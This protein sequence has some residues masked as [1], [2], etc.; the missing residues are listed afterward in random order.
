MQINLLNRGVLWNLMRVTVL[1]IVFA[2]LGMAMANASDVYSQQLLNRKVTVHAN[3]KQIAE[4]LET[5]QK[6]ANVKFIYSY[7]IIDA[8]RIVDVDAKEKKLKDVLDA[9]LLPNGVTYKVSNDKLIILLKDNDEYQEQRPLDIT[10]QNVTGKVLDEDNQPIPGVYIIEKGTSN[11]T[12]SGS[13]GG[14]SIGVENENAILVFS[15][16]GYTKQEVTVGLQENITLVLL[17]DITALEEIVVIGYGTVEKRDVTGAIGSVNA[18][19]FKEQPVLR[20][21]QILQGRTAGVNVT[22][23]SGAPGGNVTIRIRGANSITGNNDPLYV[24]DGFVGGDFNDVN[25]SDIENIQV[26]KDASATAIYGSRGA[27]GVVLITTKTGQAGAPKF[28]FTTRYSSSKVLNTWDLMDASTFANVVNQRASDLGLAPRFTDQ[29]VADFKTNGGTDWQNEIFR[30]G[31]G[32][33]YQL[34]YSGGNEAVKYFISGNLLDQDG[35]VINSYFKRYSVRT[36]IDAQLSKKFRARIKMNYIRRETNNVQGNGNIGSSIGGVTGWAPT[37]PAYD[38]NGFLTV[39]DPISSIKANPIELAQNDNIYQSNNLTTNGGFEYQILPG[40]SFD[41]GLGMSYIN[42]QDKNFSKGSIDKNASSGRQSTEYLFLQNTNNLTYHKIYKGVHD[43]SVTGALEHQLRKQ[44]QFGASANKLQFPDLGYNNITLAGGISTNAYY[45]KQTIQ[46]YIG[47]VSYQFKHRYLITA[48]A[49][50]DGSSK[51]RGSNRYSTFPSVALGWRL[52]E[53]AFM[54]GGFFDDL[55]LRASWGKTGSQAIPVYG[56]ITSFSSDNNAAGVGFTN[57]TLTP[58]II[59]GNPGNPNLKWETTAQLNFGVDMQILTG[60]LGLTVDYFDKETSDLLL[61]FPLPSYAGGG[62]ILRNVGSTKNSGFEFSLNGTIINTDQLSW[63]SSLNMTFLKNEVVSL[64]SN[65]RI[66]VDGNAGAGITNLPEGVLKPGE[67]LSAFWGLKYLG[68]WK[69]GEETEAAIYKNVPG[70]SH[71]EDINKDGVIG[72]DDYQIIGTG[73]PQTLW[74][75]NNTLKYQRFTFNAFFQAMGGYDKWNFSYGQAVTAIADAR[76]VTHKDIKDRWSPENPNSNIPAF[77]KTDVTELQSSRFVEKGD[78]IRLK[79]ISLRY[80][81]PIHKDKGINAS[82][83]FSALN[84]FTITKYKGLDP[85]AYS[86]GGGA[87]NRGADGGSYPNSKT[88]VVGINL[89]F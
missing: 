64:A 28:S 54:A 65:E 60:R 73:I 76:E 7:E 53:E 50:R 6:E 75:W 86:N 61:A 3:Q 34:D 44:D 26:L 43:L 23:S 89:S 46:S 69:I 17:Q 57:G 62:S 87:D 42:S 11:G 33:E 68:T 27:N 59:I 38:V 71:Y 24:I 9:L 10:K 30:T 36:N 83:S 88:Y 56:T 52:S 1:Q 32:Q 31:K 39:R 22:N 20:V 63:N 21:D 77:S 81:L 51:F 78:F 2:S 80:D 29:Q 82:L 8:A 79:N 19:D 47:R 45:E 58:G 14:F 55:K 16:V 5:L 70:D 4:V 48:S 66:F 85:E 84:L 37:T 12:V 13:D 67:P 35:T 18:K 49:R 72:G 41:I 15:F 74:G 40:L 25:P